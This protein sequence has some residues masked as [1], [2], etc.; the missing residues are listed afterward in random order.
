MS[1]A[2]PAD[3]ALGFL[4]LESLFR[5]PELRSGSL[6]CLGCLVEFLLSL[7]DRC[8]GGFGVGALFVKVPV[9][10]VELPFDGQSSS[11]CQELVT[12]QISLFSR[13][14]VAPTYIRFLEAA[15]STRRMASSTVL[16]WAR[17][18]VEP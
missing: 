4:Y 2:E 10:L 13:P 1:S 12:S 14:R 6:Y 9:Y 18:T 7:D 5:R 17:W 11:L 8:S 16:P 15:W 3:D